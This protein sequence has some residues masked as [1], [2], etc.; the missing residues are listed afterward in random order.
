MPRLLA[1]FADHRITLLSVSLR[2]TALLAKFVLLIYM[3]RYIGLEA[4]GIY[5]LILAAVVMGGKLISIGLYFVANR[6]MVG[7]APLRQAVIIRDQQIAYLITY[8]ISAILLLACQ[9]FLP[10]GYQHYL[11]YF[12][13]LLI[14]NHQVIEAVHVLVALHKSLAAN[15]IMFLNSIWAVVPIVVGFFLPEWRTLDIILDTWILG[16]A[17]SLLAGVMFLLPLPHRQAW[18]V[19]PNWDWIKKALWRGFPLYLAMLG[20]QAAMYVDRYVVNAFEGVALTGVLVMFWSFGNAIQVLMQTGVMQTA[21]PQMIEYY[22]KGDETAFWHRLRSLVQ[23]ILGTGSFFCLLAAVMIFP[24]LH[25]VN[26]PLAEDY[27]GVFWLML[28]GFMARFVADGLYFALY[29]R[30]R[31]RELLIANISSLL[32]SLAANIALV[33]AFGIWGAVYAQIITGLWLIGLQ[34]WYLHHTRKQ[35]IKSAYYGMPEDGA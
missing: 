18:R 1:L 11:I 25:I 21:T 17:L 12:V 35:H 2:A 32:V 13:V 22:K 7:A 19:T 23:N 14:L 28:V 10:F 27:V 15:F 8:V 4:V 24:V 5:G 31:D 20:Q 3:T 26:R 29:A 33:Y 9:P 30:H 16:S 34:G 6:E